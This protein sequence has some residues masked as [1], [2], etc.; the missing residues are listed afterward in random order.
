MTLKSSS[1]SYWS[2]RL[3]K[4]VPNTQNALSR[5]LVLVLGTM[6]SVVLAERSLLHDN[7][8]V[9]Q[10]KF[11]TTVAKKC[12][13][14]PKNPHNW[15]L[16]IIL[17]TDAEFS[18]VTIEQWYHNLIDLINVDYKLC[19]LLLPST[20]ILQSERLWFKQLLL[21]IIELT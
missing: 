21:C 15:T 18:L 2:K 3:R 9:I 6:K 11:L 8:Q 4:R 19:C 5:N 1:A 16:A 14:W 20:Q 7:A 10:F 17:E 13:F 12:K